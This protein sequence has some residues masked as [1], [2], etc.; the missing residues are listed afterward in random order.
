MS[1]AIAI[2]LKFNIANKLKILSC[3]TIVAYGIIL[4]LKES[5]QQM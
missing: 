2:N 1:I 5:S 3:V 4:S